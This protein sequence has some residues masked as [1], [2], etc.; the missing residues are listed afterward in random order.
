MTRI[1]R[2]SFVTQRLCVLLFYFL[3]FLFFRNFCFGAKAEKIGADFG[4][5]SFNPI[6]NKSAF[7]FMFI[8]IIN[9]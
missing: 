7:N 4:M 2:S 1:N 9:L 3:F 5:P 6:K 8:P